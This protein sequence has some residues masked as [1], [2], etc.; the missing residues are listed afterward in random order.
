MRWFFLTSLFIIGI[1]ISAQ[2][3][4]SNKENLITIAD[5]NS[6]NFKKDNKGSI[7]SSKEAGVAVYTISTDSIVE[8]IYNLSV[9]IPTKLPN[10]KK[11]EKLL[12]VFDGISEF[13][14]LETGE[15]RLSWQFKFG[16]KPFEKIGQTSSLSQKW[17][18]YYITFE[19]PTNINSKSLSFQLLFG[20][21]PQKL[22]I[23][24][25]ALYK[26][27]QKTL[28][29]SLPQTSITYEGMEADASW[30]KEA[31]RRIDSLRKGNLNIEFTHSG[32]K[33]KDI[34]VEVKMLDHYF[35]WGVALRAEEL[36]KDK[37]LVEKV[38]KGFN[39][40]VLE[41]DL[42]MKHFDKG[43][44]RGKLLQALDIL[45]DK[46]ID[47]KGHVLLWPG[48]NHLPANY[49]NMPPTKVEENVMNH[50]KEIL[51]AT[52]GRV[53]HWDVVNEVYTNQDLQK[54]NG[55]EDVLFKPF[56]F[57]KKTYPS[58]GRYINEYGIISQGGFNKTKQ[59][60]YYDFA[61][62]IDA[63]TGNALDGIGIQSHIGSDLTPPKRILEILD[64]YAPLKKR[65]AISE[66]TLDVKDPA[67][68]KIYTEDFLF[69]AFSHPSVKEFLFWGMIDDDDRGR[70]DI[71]KKDGSVGSMG[72]AFFGLV[73]TLW[74]TNVIEKTST[75]GRIGTR[76]FYGT[77]EYKYN[78]N[79]IEF[80]GTFDFKPD[81]KGVISVNN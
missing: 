36:L 59:E 74:T 45:K 50:I 67:I 70:V 56:T 54:K 47:V 37:T 19:V 3:D 20:Y 31:A 32:S 25:L 42:K 8:N 72:T 10:L 15:A 28:I 33:L 30:R 62:R 75:K 22:K 9:K 7:T 73:K 27:D 6:L 38:A 51:A 16:N 61:K 46:N 17:K 78:V 13:S 5:K 53:S 65:I 4:F 71:Y 35:K 41:N 79:G 66:F 29:S 2:V 48:Y 21:P 77:Y 57:M 24:N 55:S 26:F 58:L 39:L 34:D 12:L 64:F 44:S 63:K 69:A 76:A 14:S 81:T 1:H 40:V 68:R 52:E 80:K 49:K 11:D 43:L 18:T 23:K 60:W